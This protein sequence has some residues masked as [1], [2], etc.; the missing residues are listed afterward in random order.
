MRRILI[1][2]ALLSAATLPAEASTI[3]TPD[4]VTINQMQ[5][6][7]GMEAV[8]TIQIVG[9]IAEFFNDGTIPNFPSSGILW[10]NF[11]PQSNSD[12]VVTYAYNPTIIVDV[13]GLMIDGLHDTVVTQTQVSPSTAAPPVQTAEPAAAFMVGAGLI[14]L[15]TIRRKIQ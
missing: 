12:L 9:E 15:L 13:G 5:R 8:I 1:F 7:T 14:G 4:Q 2:A 6:G 3:L 10:T 11:N